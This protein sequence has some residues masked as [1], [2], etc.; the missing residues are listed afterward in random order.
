MDGHGVGAGVLTGIVAALRYQRSSVGAIQLLESLAGWVDAKGVVTQPSS[1]S[2]PEIS[3]GSTGFVEPE[4]QMCSFGAEEECGGFDLSG[5][6]SCDQNSAFWNVVG[7]LDREVAV[8]VRLGGGEV[9]EVED[10][11]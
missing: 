2:Q 9:V 6:G 1:R 3:F 4:H 11:A 5:V 8:V 10:V 7:D